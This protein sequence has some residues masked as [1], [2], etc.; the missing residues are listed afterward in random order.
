MSTSNQTVL[1]QILSIVCNVYIFVCLCI[2]LLK[3]HRTAIWNV[4]YAVFFFFSS[5]IS[6]IMS[7]ICTKYIP[8]PNQFVYICFVSSH[9]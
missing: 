4:V 7:R 5:I 2:C 6:H 9:S 8:N 1:R 3:D